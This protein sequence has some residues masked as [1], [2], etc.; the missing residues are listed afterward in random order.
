MH[1]SITLNLQNALIVI[2][3]HSL[4]LFVRS[5]EQ[6]TGINFIKKFQSIFWHKGQKASL[7]DN[8]KIFS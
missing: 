6:N 5:M 7:L 8:K 4:K 1:A 3:V 2:E